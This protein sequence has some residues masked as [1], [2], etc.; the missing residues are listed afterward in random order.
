MNWSLHNEKAA[1][2]AVV[3]VVADALFALTMFSMLHD[4]EKEELIKNVCYYPKEQIICVCTVL[5]DLT[6]TTC[7]SH[8][9]VSLFLKHPTR[10]Q[11]LGNAGE[12]KNER[13]VGLY[14]DEGIL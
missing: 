13:R 10:M 4:V 6:T 7:A 2:A 9:P 12:R 3:V 1:T 11:T 5:E 14:V 8:S